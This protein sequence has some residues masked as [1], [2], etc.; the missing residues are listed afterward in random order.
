VGFFATDEADGLTYASAN[1]DLA[2]WR[3]A[4]N[5]T[6]QPL[7]GYEGPI[8][9]AAFAHRPEGLVYATSS[10]DTI[11]I[12]AAEV[13]KQLPPGLNLIAPAE[14]TSVD[15]SPKGHTVASGYSNGQVQLWD[16]QA[17]AVQGAALP[18]HTDLV[19]DVA[20]SPDG[21]LLATASADHT[22]RLW[23]VADGQPVG[24]PLTGHSDRVWDVAFSPDGKQLASSS[25]DGTVR[26]WDAAG[27]PRPRSRSSRK[28]CI[29]HRL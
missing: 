25:D 21:S 3:W 26:F 11:T 20:F 28:F 18:G 2:T 7:L 8:D 9:S 14:V 13:E 5:E 1:N 6:L 24:A 17:G 15:F 10:G 29:W 19:V 27:Q 16:T 12:W 22:V 4:T 23:R